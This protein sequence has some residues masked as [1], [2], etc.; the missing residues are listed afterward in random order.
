MQEELTEKEIQELEIEAR[1]WED[2]KEE[3][4]TIFRLYRKPYWDE[5][6]ADLYYRL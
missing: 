3:E 1:D 4:E 5:Y 2:I 6:E